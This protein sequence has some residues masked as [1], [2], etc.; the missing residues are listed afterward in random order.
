MFSWSPDL[1]DF[2]AVQSR[3]TTQTGNYKISTLRVFS[4]LS[5][6]KQVYRFQW[7]HCHRNVAIRG[8][9]VGANDNDGSLIQ[10]SQVVCDRRQRV[11]HRA[12]VLAQWRLPA[13]TIFQ[14]AMSESHCFS[15][16]VAQADNT[17]VGAIQ[18]ADF[19]HTSCKIEI[20]HYT[21]YQSIQ[22]QDDSPNRSDSSI[23][24]FRPQVT[25]A[26][27]VHCTTLNVG[28]AER[29]SSEGSI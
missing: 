6:T 25:S 28:I 7:S 19:A 23:L 21:L 18:H 12:N 3:S 10:P 1:T 4:V 5:A 9:A 27:R 26:H 14:I 13:R 29:I 17:W 11:Y 15:V 22:F 8:L 2:S 20:T 16:I 24:N